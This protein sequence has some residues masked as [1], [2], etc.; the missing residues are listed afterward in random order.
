MGK[1]TSKFELGGK[2][3]T[4]EIDPPHHP[5]TEALTVDGVK[6]F[7]ADRFARGHSYEAAVGMFNDQFTTYHLRLKQLRRLL[8]LTRWTQRG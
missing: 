4:L 3:F 2:S 6:V 1:L 8:W 5:D 7:L